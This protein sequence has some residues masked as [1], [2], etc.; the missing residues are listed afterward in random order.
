MSQ[1]L[2][3]LSYLFNW[4]IVDLQCC[5]KLFSF[6]NILLF[7]PFNLGDS[8][9]SSSSPFCS[10][11]PSNLLLILSGVF[12]FSYCILQLY[13]VIFFFFSTL[14]WN[15]HCV[16][17]FFWVCWASLWSLPWTLYWVDCL[18]PLFLFLRSL[19]FVPLF[20]TYFYVFLFC[21]VLCVCIR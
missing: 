13:L 17:P 6:K 11:I 21:P 7:F 5:I 15:S 9:Y 1:K 12:N 14:C 16:H 19:S 10:S 2:H 18:S 3:K 8:H 4:L 20:G